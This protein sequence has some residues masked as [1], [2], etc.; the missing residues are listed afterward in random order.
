M[1]EADSP[2]ISVLI[3]AFNEERLI[4]GVIDSVRASFAVIGFDRFEIVVCDNNSTDQTASIAARNGA[5]VVFEPHNQIA[6]ARNTAARQGTGNWFIFLDGD[7]Y[8]NPGLLKATID[9]FASGKVCGG[10]STIGF[11]RT[12]LG[13][14]NERLARF[15]NRISATFQVAAGSYLFCLKAAW[16]ETGGFDESVYAGAEIFFTRQLKRWGKKRELRFRILTQSPVV[17]SARKM[18]WYSQW[19]LLRRFFAM[20]RPFAIKRREACGLWYTRPVD[21]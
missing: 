9:A 14:L 1:A 7:T 19:E 6:R 10:G 17:T 4:E 21:K 16:G 11:D 12:D 2:A 13:F 8:L 3:P 20:A 18:E 15:W 5:K